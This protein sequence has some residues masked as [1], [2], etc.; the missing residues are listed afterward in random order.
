MYPRL[1]RCLVASMD[2]H[3]FVSLSL[4]AAD[5]TWQHWAWWD[6]R[7]YILATHEYLVALNGGHPFWVSETMF[8]EIVGRVIRA[9][10]EP[11]PEPEPEL[12]AEL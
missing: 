1:R 8:A 6:R 2:V 5:G 4:L 10:Y 3:A 11:E 7:W 9:R 12:D